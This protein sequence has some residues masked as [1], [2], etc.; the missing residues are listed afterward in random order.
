M[1]GDFFYPPLSLPAS[2]PHSVLLVAGGVGVNPL[3]SILRD[4]DTSEAA[5]CDQVTSS[6]EPNVT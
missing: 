2:Q 6:R 3:V 1:G 5:S 4:L